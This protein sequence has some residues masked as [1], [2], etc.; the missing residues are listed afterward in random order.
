MNFDTAIIYVL[1]LIVVFAI[2]VKRRK[3]RETQDLHRHIES[4]TAGLNEPTSLHPA[5]DPG[6]CIGSGACASACP[7]KAIGMIDGSPQLVNGSACIGHGACLKACPTGAINLVFGTER[8]GVDIPQV[9]PFF[10]TNV[11]GIFIAGEL[12]GM[13][14]I[15][16]AVEQGKQAMNTISERKSGADML[17]VVIIGAGPA[18]LAASLAAKEKRM[19]FVTLEQESSLGG[20]V[21][22]FPR[23]KIAMTH[24]MQIPTVGKVKLGEVSKEALLQLW[25]RVTS[26]AGLK[27]SFRE[28]VDSIQRT[29][30]AFLVKTAT[31]SY[32]TKSVLLAIGRRGTPRRLEVPGEE[33]AKVVYRLIDPMQ[34]TGQHVLVVGGGDAAVEAA[35]SVSERS[36]TTVSLSYR[37]N[38]FNRI[39]PGNRD[40]VQAAQSNG[41]VRVLLESEV[42]EIKRDLVMLRHGKNSFSLRNEAVIV[43]AGGLMPTQFLRDI[44]VM[45]ETRHGEA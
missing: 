42:V 31:Q 26:Q 29:G 41:R 15:H 19:R 43:C 8:R 24:P 38:A 1:P 10:E 28:R 16:K 17:D 39:K 44:G 20:T 36:G 34:Y 4:V 30:N 7:E 2:Y 32:Q 23:N 25:T 18:G 6:R 45:V 27:V 21:Y 3:R 5:F 9:D 14:L 11:P 40:R 13:G 12:G 35:V 22:H 37:G 33:Q